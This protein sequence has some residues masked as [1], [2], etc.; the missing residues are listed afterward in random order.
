MG[1]VVRVGKCDDV[2]GMVVEVCSDLS[3][4]I[5]VGFG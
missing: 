4:C 5:K 1:F 3:V 2:K